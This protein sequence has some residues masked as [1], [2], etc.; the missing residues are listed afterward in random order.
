MAL[1]TIVYKDDTALDYFRK[2]IDA[3]NAGNGEDNA[4]ELVIWNERNWES[5]KKAAPSGGKTIF[6]GAVKDIETLM[7]F[8]DVKYERWGIKYGFNSRYA[9]ITADTVFVKDKARYD[10]FMKDFNDSLVDDEVAAKAFP[11][12]A[13]VMNKEG[14]DPAQAK[15]KAAGKFFGQAGLAL[16]T[17]GASIAAQKAWDYNKNLTEKQQQLYMYAAGHFCTNYLDEFLEL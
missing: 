1:L 14:S 15:R 2:V 5:R 12:A 7:Y 13:A 4:V 8:A 6:I 3:L 10:A 16:A 9:V 17:G 11:G